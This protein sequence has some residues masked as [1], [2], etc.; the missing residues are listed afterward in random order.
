LRDAWRH[1]L[2]QRA[3]PQDRGD[4]KGRTGSGRARRG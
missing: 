1:A 2:R 4:I 3:R